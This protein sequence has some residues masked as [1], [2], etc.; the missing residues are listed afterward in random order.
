MK[1]YVLDASIILKWVLGDRKE[2][3]HEKAI[4]LLDAWA[5]G[6]VEIGV[7]SLWTYEI[8]NLLGREFP[9]DALQKMKLL[10]NLNLHVVESTEQSYQMCFRWMQE[11][12]VTFYDASYL[13]AAYAID[14]I[15]L[16]GD[17]KFCKKMENDKRICLLKDWDFLTLN[18]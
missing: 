8:A 5:S 9:Q 1:K 17:E 2:P 13:A 14:A 4:S 18:A 10:L 15:L 7:P 11:N 3:D 6:I 16:T 12:H